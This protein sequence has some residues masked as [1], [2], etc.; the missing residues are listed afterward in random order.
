ML[1]RFMCKASD[2]RP[3]V[4]ELYLYDE[5]GGMWGVSAKAIVD[6]LAQLRES[7]I[8]AL[9][10][11]VNSPGG[12][13]FD[14]L[15]VFNALQRFSV[16]TPV[17]VYVDGIAASMASVIAM[18][19]DEIVMAPN[20]MMMIHEPWGVVV[21]G[22]DDMLSRAAVL[23]KL[24]TTIRDTYARETGNSAEQV[25]AWMAD[26]TWM[27]AQEAVERGF[28]TRIGDAVPVEEDPVQSRWAAL[29]RFRA[30]PDRARAIPAS[31]FRTAAMSRVTPPSAALTEGPQ[32]TEQEKKA[33]AEK[34]ALE[35][36]IAELEGRAAAH[37]RAELEARCARLEAAASA[38]VAAPG[39]VGAVL[40][41]ACS[42][43][44]APVVAKYNVPRSVRDREARSDD[45]A[46]SD[47]HR[48]A[49]HV[50][51][52]GVAKAISF[53]DG[54]SVQDACEQSGYR[55]T[56][57]IIRGAAMSAGA[58]D[59][60]GSFLHAEVQPAFI[61]M[62]D[63]TPGL[64]DLIPATSKI[65]SSQPSIQFDT[66][67]SGFTG[68]WVGE[69]PSAGSPEALGT[70]SKTMVAKKMRIE[71]LMSRD[72]LRSAPNIDV[73]VLQ[74]LLRRSKQIEEIAFVEGLGSVNQPRGLEVAVGAANTAAMTASP[75]YE[76]AHLD[77]LYLL[78]RLALSKIDPAAG[79]AFIISET[80]KYGLMGF[81]NPQGSAFP[82]AEEMQR[83]TLLGVPFRDSALIGTDKVYAFAPGEVLYFEQLAML[84]E[85]DNTY[86]DSSGTTHSAS[87]ADQVCIRMFRKLD[88]DL[89]HD[90]AVS[91]KSA[92]TWGA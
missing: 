50:G 84:V 67:T 15:A 37:D 18:A 43:G 36:K 6:A 89:K 3:D 21:G 86:R 57:E 32:M 44:K 60:G 45:S 78:K 34:A 11:Y 81:I 58:A 54:I 77:L 14:G 24:S 79:R 88:M 73:L 4:G 38:R 47:T 31:G 56:A 20:A 40:D 46:T 8:T 64:T 51:R 62:L 9:S 35:A 71:C 33:A 76:N 13:V 74:K 53:L 92:V 22:S 42:Q 72:L 27:S 70:G 28:A 41:D 68:A 59:A 55:R 52:L 19:G 30:M 69:N 29:D 10:V 23:E 66:V 61:D 1:P 26:E 12:D 90:E 75:D 49:L 91:V 7:G 25:A 5:I 82:Y 83:G 85:S 16:A 2:T 17:T 63:A 87:A 48:L 39:A 65:R 80:H